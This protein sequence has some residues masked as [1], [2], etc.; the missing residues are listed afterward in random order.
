MLWCVV[1]GGVVRWGTLMRSG[2]GGD[3]WWRL[4][5][6]SL[7]VSILALGNVPRAVAQEESGDA[8]RTARAFSLYRWQED[9]SYL[10]GKDRNL[11]EQF[12]YIPLPGLPNS[13][14]SLGGEVR[15]RIDAYDPY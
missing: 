9:Y 2:F 4:S 15:H 10:A 8:S 11:W 13:W 7:L 6:A 1:H 14:L 12:K 5:A 3:R